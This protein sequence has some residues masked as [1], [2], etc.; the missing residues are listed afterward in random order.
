MRGSSYQLKHSRMD[1]ISITNIRIYSYKNTKYNMWLV[2]CHPLLVVPLHLPLLENHQ[3][4][5]WSSHNKYSHF[6]GNSCTLLWLPFCTCCQ[7]SLGRLD[8]LREYETSSG[9][10]DI[11]REYDTSS[12]SMGQPQGVWDS[13]REYV[14][15][16]IA[17]ESQW[18]IV[19]THWLHYLLLWLRDHSLSTASLNDE[20][21]LLD[22]P[23]ILKVTHWVT[24]HSV[25]CLV[26]KVIKYT[27]N[28]LSVSD[29]LFYLVS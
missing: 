3:H 15:S 10:W 8:I 2:S 13:L 1:T 24:V 27:L 16:E 14:Y 9:R 11:F 19:I 22:S 17:L 7:T 4:S 20:S 28:S 21:F 23:N 12:G 18:V 26:F 25:T 5:F 29:P 6:Y